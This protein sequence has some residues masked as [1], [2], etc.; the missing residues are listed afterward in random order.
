[1]LQRLT[2]WSGRPVAAA[3]LFRL[4]VIFLNHI[5]AG[6]RP[7][8]KV[9][10]PAV[11]SVQGVSSPTRGPRTPFPPPFPRGEN[12]FSAGHPGRRSQGRWWATCFHGTDSTFRRSP[13]CARPGPIERGAV[14]PIVRAGW[15]FGRKG[16]RELAVHG[17]GRLSFLRAAFTPPRCHRSEKVNN[18]GKRAWANGF[19]PAEA[20]CLWRSG[21]GEK[22]RW[23]WDSPNLW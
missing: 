5:T 4:G 7:G 12:P 15:F 19:S 22:R 23:V 14:A 10:H 16:A 20:G 17:E 3:S 21:T 13:G 6:E 9:C 11:F 8:P 18:A 1:M 2:F